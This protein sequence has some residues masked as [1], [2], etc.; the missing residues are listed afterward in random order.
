MLKQI[1]YLFT[2][3]F[4]LLGCSNSQVIKNKPID[5]FDYN[6]IKIDSKNIITNKKTNQ[7]INGKIIHDNTMYYIVKDGLFSI[8]FAKDMLVYFNQKQVSK[9]ETNNT[10]FNLT[11]NK[12]NGKMTNFIFNDIKKKN[13]IFIK[14]D[15]KEKVEYIKEIQKDKNIYGVF[16]KNKLDFYNLEDDKLDNTINKEWLIKAF[17]KRHYKFSKGFDKILMETSTYNIWLNA[18]KFDLEKDECIRTLGKEKYDNIN[19]IYNIENFALKLCRDSKKKNDITTH[20]REIFSPA[21]QIFLNSSVMCHKES[22][23][24]NSRD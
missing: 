12:K 7:P 24:E 21:T 17:V 22:H 9:I 16:S 18:L 1:M 19:K 14:F 15:D 20:W 13:K 11:I 8:V 3:I 23:E 10:N 2:I 4:I 5:V 6:Q